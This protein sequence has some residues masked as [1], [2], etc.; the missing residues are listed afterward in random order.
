V[1]IT[2]KP[3]SVFFPE[4]FGGYLRTHE[5]LQKQK[6]K[7]HFMPCKPHNLKLYPHPLITLN[8][9]QTQN[10]EFP[11]VG[12]LLH[13]LLKQFSGKEHRHSQKETLLNLLN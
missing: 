10:K 6:N 5:L 1:L 12:I 8:N 2:Y 3:T 4:I 9:K 11:A 13:G 7:L